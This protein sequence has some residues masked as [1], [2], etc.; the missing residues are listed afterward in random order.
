MVSIRVEGITKKFGD[1]LAVNRV[2]FEVKDGEF[3]TLLGPSGCGKT[4]ILRIISGLLRQDEGDVFIN[5]ELI[6][7]IPTHKRGNAMVFQ[8]YALFPHLNVFENVAYGLKRRTVGKQEMTSRVLESLKLVRLGGFE[9]R[10]PSQLSGGQQQRVA[11]ARALVIKPRA[12][13]MDEPLSNLDA[14]LRVEMRGEVRALQKKLGMT[15]I[16]VTHD[17]EEALTVSD[18]IAVMRAGTIEQIGDP[19]AIYQDPVNVHVADFIGAVDRLAGQLLS[20]DPT[21]STAEIE[22]GHHVVRARPLGRISAGEKAT[23]GIRAERLRIVREASEKERCPNIIEGIVTSVKFTGA[24]VRYEVVD[25][26][27]GQPFHV[28]E[29]VLDNSQVVKRDQKVSV[30]FTEA[31]A[32]VFQE[33]S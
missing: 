8:N 5:E 21:R 26:D 13:L 16:Y 17:Q 10:M 32:Y 31:S 2:S 20:C 30:C 23:L 4:T 3:F 18:R 12:L 15:T 1:Y 25:S 29:H 22:I 33:G 27:T 6:N 24:S 7:E 9:K 11:V 14:K 19:I 28:Q